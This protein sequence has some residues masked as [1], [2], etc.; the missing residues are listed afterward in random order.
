MKLDNLTFIASYSLTETDIETYNKFYN[1]ILNFRRVYIVYWPY[2][3]KVGDNIDN[4]KYINDI[5]NKMKETHKCNIINNFKNGNIY[6]AEK[7]I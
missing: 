6:Y 4:G 7:I 2:K 3:D 1:Y 5:F